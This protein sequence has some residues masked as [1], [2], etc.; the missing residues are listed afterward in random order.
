MKRLQDPCF[1]RNYLISPFTEEFVF[2]SC[3]L[4]L[5]TPKLYTRTAVLTTPLFF[6][7]AHLH[8]IVEGLK[9]NSATF[10]QLLAQHLFQFT[11][12]YIFGVY[13]SFLFVRTGCF[14]PTFV[15][16]SFCNFMGFP[17]IDEL[18]TSSSLK[19]SKKIFIIL[20]YVVGFVLFF[21]L[22][23][24]LTDPSIFHN[25]LYSAFRNKPF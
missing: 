15:I 25:N 5:V 11:Y 14:L 21:Q 9:T 18:L 22:I 4:P 8:H 23:N 7:V 19:K 24:P 17:H 10:G 1:L 20:C 3:M 12:T 16:H 2:R 13:S 6:G